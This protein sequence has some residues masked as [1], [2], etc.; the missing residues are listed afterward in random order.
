VLLVAGTRRR[1]LVAVSTPAAEATGRVPTD[2]RCVCSLRAPASDADPRCSSRGSG[3]QTFLSY[4]SCDAFLT[5]GAA[6]R[7]F[8][9]KQAPLGLRG[10]FG[11]S[12]SSRMRAAVR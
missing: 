2:Y 8:R 3:P 11:V 9:P 4:C 7:F 12:C 6:Q 1:L 10:L 5:G